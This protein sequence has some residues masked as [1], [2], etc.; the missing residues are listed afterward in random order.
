MSKKR[1]YTHILLDRSGSMDGIGYGPT[2]NAVNDYIAKMA[3]DPDLSSRVSLTLFDSRAAMMMPTAKFALS[4]SGDRLALEHLFTGIKPKNAPKIDRTNYIPNGGT[5]LRDAIGETITL[6]D[7][8]E[9]RE[10][11][12]I[13]FVVVTDGYENTSTKWTQE[14]IS[15]LIGDR[16]EKGWLVIYLGA[17]HDAMMQASALNVAAANT[18]SYAKASS[19]AATA[20]VFRGAKDYAM[21]G[22]IALSAFTAGEREDAVKEK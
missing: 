2:C 20:A 1:V 14:Q 13:A 21:T 12:T 22:N 4:T 5:P 10:G 16:K 18:M 6:I 3:A 15:K 7:K 8:Q 11:E 9:R 17:D 19:E